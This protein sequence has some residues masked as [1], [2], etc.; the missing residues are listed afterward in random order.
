MNRIFRKLVT[1]E[2]LAGLDLGDCLHVSA[3]C[4]FIV[5]PW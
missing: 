3:G 2:P 5:R 4:H 1:I